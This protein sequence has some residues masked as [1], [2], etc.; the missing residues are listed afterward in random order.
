[1]GVYAWNDMQNLQADCQNGDIDAIVHMGDHV[2]FWA[3]DDNKRGDAYMNAWQPALAE[4]PWMPI[5][6][7]V[8]LFCFSSSRFSQAFLTLATCVASA[9]RVQRRRQLLALHQRDLGADLRPGEQRRGGDA[10]A[11]SHCCFAPPRIHC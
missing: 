10:R 1:M 3:G 8:R 4:C 11:R 7:N 9:A 6:G 2:Y 5:I